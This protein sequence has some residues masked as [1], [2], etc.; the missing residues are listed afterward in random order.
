MTMNQQ[1]ATILVMLDLSA[2]FD[3]VSHKFV[4]G[5][6]KSKLG[7]RDTPFLCPCVGPFP[8][9]GLTLAWFIWDRNLALQITL[10]S[11]YSV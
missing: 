5:Y 8:S 7:L 9:V 2:A 11:V 3:I 1:Q 4:L 6:L 10:Y